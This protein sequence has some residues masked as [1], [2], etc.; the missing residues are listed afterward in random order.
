[1]VRKLV[2]ASRNKGKILEIREL[3]R[4]LPLIIVGLEGYP[5]APEVEETGVTFF[6][7]AIIKARAFGAYTGELTLADDSGLEVDYLNGAPGVFSARYGEK[8]WSDR[9]RYQ[10][11]LKELEGVPDRLRTARFRC[12]VALFDPLTGAIK[13]SEGA[14]EGVIAGQPR[15]E[16]GFGYDPVFYLPEYDQTMAELPEGKKNQLSHRARAIESITPKLRR[17]LG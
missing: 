13:S 14:V 15:G 17:F 2:L 12:V 11:L 7:N 16:N 6:D 9:Q 10:F 4:E 3:L 5:D 1:M 8:G